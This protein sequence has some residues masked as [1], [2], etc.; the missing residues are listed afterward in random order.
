M[1]VKPWPKDTY[2]DTHRDREEPRQLQT[3]FGCGGT[4]DFLLVAENHSKEI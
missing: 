1:L 4:L 2:K 3:F